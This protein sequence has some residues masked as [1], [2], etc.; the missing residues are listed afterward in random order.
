MSLDVTAALKACKAQA[1]ID[2]EF[3]LE[4]EEYTKIVAA[5]AEALQRTPLTAEACAEADISTL[6][7]DELSHLADLVQDL[8]LHG[9]FDEFATYCSK[10][11]QARALHARAEAAAAIEEARVSNGL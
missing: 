4:W 3:S 11:M 2:D 9:G 6:L 1:E 8:F 5:F 10:E 7:I